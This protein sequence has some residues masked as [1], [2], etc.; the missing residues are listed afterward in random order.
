MR[1]SR[2]FKK[3]FRSNSKSRTQL[4]ASQDLINF[5]HEESLDPNTAFINTSPSFS[6]A[7]TA[8]ATPVSTPTLSNRDEKDRT[9]IKKVASRPVKTEVNE[10]QTIES[11]D[12]QQRAFRKEVST[13]LR[14]RRGCM[15][16]LK[17]EYESK[18]AGWYKMRKDYYK[19]Q[20]HG[21]KKELNRERERYDR[22]HKKYSDLKEN[23]DKLEKMCEFLLKSQ[24]SLDSSST[25]RHRLNS[26]Y[27][28]KMDKPLAPSYYKADDSVDY[29]NLPVSSRGAMKST[30]HY[31]SINKRDMEIIRRQRERY[32]QEQAL[33]LYN[34]RVGESST[35]LQRD[36]TKPYIPVAN[37]VLTDHGYGSRYSQYEAERGHPSEWQMR[38]RIQYDTDRSCYPQEVETFSDDEGLFPGWQTRQENRRKRM[39]EKVITV[40]LKPPMESRRSQEPTH[41][42]ANRIQ[43]GSALYGQKTYRQIYGSR[44]NTEAEVRPPMKVQNNL[45]RVQDYLNKVPENGKFSPVPDMYDAF[46]EGKGASDPRVNPRIESM[47]SNMSLNDLTKSSD[48]EKENEMTVREIGEPVFA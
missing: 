16:E 27:S 29:S 34:E 23:Y 36:L 20:I 31:S 43:L 12:R 2:L 13:R 22:L 37:E 10:D 18:D 35:Y 21:M 19:L 45:E 48:E 25:R 3:M 33:R 44:E 30:K 17:E 4:M 42:R 6:H 8:E 24:E 28:L 15:E 46:L 41:R 5:D 26:A 7:P 39:T 14:D 11:K 1:A 38:E 9:E 40:P 32:Q 47:L